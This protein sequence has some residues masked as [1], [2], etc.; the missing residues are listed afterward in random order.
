MQCEIFLFASFNS[1]QG[2]G[3]E[4]NFELRADRRSGGRRPRSTSYFP[5]LIV[6]GFGARGGGWREPKTTVMKAAVALSRSSRL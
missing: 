4:L 2:R 5:S 1:A 3:V 6:V